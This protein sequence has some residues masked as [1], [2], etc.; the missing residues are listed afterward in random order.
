MSMTN[1]P[2]LRRDSLEPSP[3]APSESMHMHTYIQMLSFE[4]NPIS[5]EE[6]TSSST[7]PTTTK[8]A[9][10][11]CATAC[12][13]EQRALTSCVDS[14]RAEREGDDGD[15]ATSTGASNPACLAVAVEAWTR[16]CE[17]ANLREELEGQKETST[18]KI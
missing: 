6:G 15:G 13:V 7:A 11:A 17:D 16:C 2:P 18:S 14:I 10:T 5:D 1:Q 4:N 12:V 3:L 9:P 8:V